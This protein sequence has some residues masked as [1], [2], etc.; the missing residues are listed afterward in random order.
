[1][2]LN[3]N[4]I[5]LW[6][7]SH[8]ANIIIVFCI[9]SRVGSDAFSAISQPMICRYISKY[10]DVIVNHLSP[11]YIQF[12]RSND[13]IN[14]KKELFF[15]KYGLPGII[16]VVDGTHVAVTAL[17]HEIE[18]A[19]MNRKGFHSINVQ[20]ICDA[21][22]IITNVNARYPG[23][24]HDSFIFNNSRVYTFLENIHQ[25]NPNEWNF[26]IGNNVQS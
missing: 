8:Y 11:I 5:I 25:T 3:L 24:T 20:I 2:C 26:L 23:S 9:F 17:S 16:G 7:D 15:Q 1:M 14:A 6:N 10:S 21:N 4:I 18:N 12:P 22:M 19:Y 13:N